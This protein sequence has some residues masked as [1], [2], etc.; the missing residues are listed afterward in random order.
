MNFEERQQLNKRKATLD[1]IF[2][3]AMP[4]DFTRE[5]WDELYAE[6]DEINAKLYDPTDQS[7]QERN[8]SDPL[9]GKD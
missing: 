6:Y 7:A 2:S 5:E 1:Q 9:Y 8:L 3:R 4:S